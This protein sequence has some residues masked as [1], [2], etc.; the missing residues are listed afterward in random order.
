MYPPRIKMMKKAILTPRIP[1]IPN[2]PKMIP[3]ANLTTKMNSATI[4]KTKKIAKTNLTSKM[5]K[6]MMTTKGR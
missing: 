3:M 4:A 1:K 6:K 2:N 5:A